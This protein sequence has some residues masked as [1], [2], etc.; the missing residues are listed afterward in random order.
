MFTLHSDENQ[1]KKNKSMKK[2][3]RYGKQCIVVDFSSSS[4]GWIMDKF[5]PNLRGAARAR[6]ATTFWLTASY[7]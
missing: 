3:H 7:L 6:P 4:S 1:L 2:K 5:I